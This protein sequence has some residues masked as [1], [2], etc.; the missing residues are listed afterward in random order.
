MRGEEIV[1]VVKDI[2]SLIDS[3]NEFDK[4]MGV[5]EHHRA[6]DMQDVKRGL[7]SGE[8]PYRFD[9]IYE[10]MTQRVA[11]QKELSRCFALLDSAIA[12]TRTTVTRFEKTASKDEIALDKAAQMFSKIKPFDNNDPLIK[13]QLAAMDEF[14]KSIQ[15]AESAIKSLSDLARGK[16]AGAIRNEPQLGRAFDE[17]SKVSSSEIDEMSGEFVFLL[18]KIQYYRD[19]YKL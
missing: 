14:K 11:W 7:L 19:T 4:Q 2:K 3:L 9:E 15:F 17:I 12:N 1:D 16:L 5:S 13:K 8:K 10:S 18:K 6:R